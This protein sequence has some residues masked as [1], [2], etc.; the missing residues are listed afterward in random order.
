MKAMA[1]PSSIPVVS[2]AAT[3]DI[4]AFI[5]KCGLDAEPVFRD[6]GLDVRVS[7]DPYQLIELAKFTR[8][9][10]AAEET[11]QCATIGMQVGGRQDP[12]RWGAFGYLVLNS[13]TIG[14]ALRNVVSH[15]T[16]WQTGTHFAFRQ[17]KEDIGVEYA[18]T[19]PAVDDRPQDAEFSIAYVKNIVD[20]LNE[21]PA[22][23]SDVFFEHDPI[24]GMDAYEQ[25]FGVR[26]LFNQPTNAIYYPRLYE[27]RRIAF[28]DLQLFPVI[29]RH[30]MDMASAVPKSESL[31]GDVIYHIRQSLP[32]G[33]AT[34]ENIAA[35][36]GIQSRTLQRRLKQD[37]VSFTDLLDRVRHE[38]ATHHLAETSMSISEI[39]YLL[40]YCD[41]SAFIKAFRKQTGTTPSRFRDAQGDG[42]AGGAT[43]DQ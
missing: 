22:T 6:A 29:K 23:P 37:G 5:R 9:L 26:P 15:A 39:A 7:T 25:V 4:A 43:G 17:T 27:N 35:V 12:A 40:G 2:A 31:E 28:A 32:R 1:A 8:L 18:I 42:P 13:P 10:K 11:T 20:R 3:G 33:T 21:R 19:H 36:M 38:T 24:A 34:L 16:I 14:D 30:L 41:T